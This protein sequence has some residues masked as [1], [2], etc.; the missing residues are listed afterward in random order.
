MSRKSSSMIALVAGAMLVMVACTNNSSEE[1]NRSVKAAVQPEVARAADEAPALAAVAYV[2]GTAVHTSDVTSMTKY[3]EDGSPLSDEVLTPLFSSFVV[4]K[5]R[6]DELALIDRAIETTDHH[7]ELYSKADL[8]LVLSIAENAAE[9]VWARSDFAAD[10]VSYMTTTSDQSEVT[11]A[12]KFDFKSCLPAEV[13]TP[14]KDQN[15]AQDQDSKQGQ[16]VKQSQDKQPVIA[17]VVAEPVCQGVTA[18]V[19]MKQ[20]MAPKEDSK[21]AQSKDDPKK[22]SQTQGQN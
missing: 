6:V 4:L 8:I 17:P 7:F 14:D 1:N 2:P 20:Q 13:I 12:L 18:L 10:H 16:D 11:S 21:Q 15:Q 5:S 3:A 9:V 22:G 19:T